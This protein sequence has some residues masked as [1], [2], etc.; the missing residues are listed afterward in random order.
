MPRGACF[1]FGAESDSSKIVVG[2][3]IRK[4]HAA[5]DQ[6][7]GILGVLDRRRPNY[8]TFVVELSAEQRRCSAHIDA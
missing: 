2:R 5:M 7:D 8:A 4:D 6:M 3:A 1:D